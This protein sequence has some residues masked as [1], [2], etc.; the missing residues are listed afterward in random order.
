MPSESRSENVE[1]APSTAESGNVSSMTDARNTGG[2]AVGGNDLPP[3]PSPSQ[4]QSD[5]TIDGRANHTP[6]HRQPQ[7][8]QYSP[9]SHASPRVD[10]KMPPTSPMP[11]SQ[12]QGQQQR[13][14][15]HPSRR[16]ASHNVQNIHH[17]QQQQQQ[18]RSNT[19]YMQRKQELLQQQ[20]HR[21]SRIVP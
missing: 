13:Q 8:Q 15:P 18:Q 11:P 3:S 17:R 14:E 2:N 9:A 19:L 6:Q 5:A 1:D 12:Q 20:P 10:R 21:R 7:Q 4:R 16:P